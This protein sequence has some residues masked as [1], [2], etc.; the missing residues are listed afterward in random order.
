MNLQ[1]WRPVSQLKVQETPLTRAKIPVIDAHNH[2]RTVTD[3]AKLVSDMDEFNIRTIINLDGVYADNGFRHEQKR[4]AD[5]YPG[6]FGVLCQIDV[7]QIDDPDFGKKMDAYITDCVDRGCVGIKFHKGMVG[8][9]AKDAAGNFIMP[10]DPRLVAVWDCAARHNIPVLIHIADPVAFFTP[11]DKYN[12][13]FEELHEHPTWT[14][15][16]KGTPGFAELLAAQERMLKSNPQTTYVIPHVGSHAEDLADVSRMMDLYPNMYVDTAERIHELG[17][18]PYTARDFIIKYA[19]RVIYGTDLVPNAH[20]TSYNYRFFET[21][22]EYFP[23]NKLEEHNQGRWMIYGVFLPD[24]VLRKV[25]VDNA[26]RLY[27]KKK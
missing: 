22:D 15:Y 6:R 17:R 24:D 10:D 26:D 25:Y 3:V 8:L 14:Y 7:T 11:T 9:S 12:E 16:D 18:Q 21:R 2:L 20:N 5:A 19:D 4:F 27:F 23:Y 13:R 1:D